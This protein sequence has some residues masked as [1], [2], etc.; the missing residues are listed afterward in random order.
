MVSS[1]ACYGVPTCH[2]AKNSIACRAQHPLDSSKF[3]LIIK[4]DFFP[5]SR[6]SKKAACG[7]SILYVRMILS[8]D[9][10]NDHFESWFAW[11]EN[12]KL[13]AL[14]LEGTCFTAN[15]YLFA[16]S[17]WPSTQ[18]TSKPWPNTPARGFICSKTLTIVVKSQY[19]YKYFCLILW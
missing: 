14:D 2:V 16:H 3:L 4:N 15:I 10:I 6:I 7:A 19:F 9:Y 5:S 18:G 11:Q 12:I 8:M 1:N 17:F 13:I